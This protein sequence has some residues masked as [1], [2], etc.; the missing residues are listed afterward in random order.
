MGVIY[1]VAEAMKLGFTNGD[2]DWCNLGQGQPEVGELEGAPPRWSR[3]DIRPQDHAYGPID[4]IPELREAIAAHYNRLYRRGS[5]SRYT[6]E[7]VSVAAGG[8][9]VLSRAFAALGDVTLGYQIPDYT[10]YEDMIG[11]HQHRFTPVQVPAPES[12]GFALTPERLRR[13]VADKG[14]GAFVISNPCN[15]TGRVIR[16]DDLAAYVRL[17]REAACTLVLDEFYSHFVYDGDRPAPGPVSGAAFVEDV[18]RDPV[19]LVDGLTKSFR[20]PGWRVGWAVGPREM[21]ANLGRAA[22][23]IDGGLGVPIQRA[24]VAVLEPARADQETEALRRAFSRKRNL[25]VERLGAMGIRV[26]RPSEG[27]FYVWASIAG[28]PAPWNDAEVFF[29]RALEQRVLTV[30]GVFFDVN[31]GRRRRGPSPLASWV[32]FSFGPPEENVRLGLDRLEAMLSTRP[33]RGLVESAPE[34]G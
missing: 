16:G 7:N 19:L 29:R 26:A 22:S 4:G 17:A 25:M 2:P 23:A 6:A 18:E 27:T 3:I 20:Y 9:L 13:E 14:L 8:R 12:D 28:L 11:Y 30:P 5:R 21:V 10:A 24:A 33:A 32:R 31:P 34:P 15:P 1:V